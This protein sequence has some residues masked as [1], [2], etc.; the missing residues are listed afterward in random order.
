MA[1]P[2]FKTCCDCGDSLPLANFVPVNSDLFPDGVI[3]FCE[4]CLASR[5]KKKE[6]NFEYIDRLCQW[7]GIPFD[8]QQWLELYGK[9]NYKAFASYAKLNLSAFYPVVDW[10]GCY[11][12][13]KEIQDAAGLENEVPE[14]R[15]AEI[16]RLRKK[17]GEQYDEEDLGYLEDLFQGILQTQNIA[18]KL[19]TDDAIK[20]C[21]ISLLI[22]EKIRASEDFDKILKSYDALRKSADFTSK[23]VKN[24]CDFDS[25]G[26]LFLYCE[27]MGWVN[28]FYDGAMRDTVDLTMRDTQN[29]VR[30]LY[31]NET[32]IGE[33]VERRIQALKIADE[34]EESILSVK[35]D[36]LDDFDSE[37]YSAMDKEDFDEEAGI[38]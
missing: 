27:K 5:I 30:N 10:K 24:A 12:K 6:G 26:E 17:W 22:D 3:P 11:E 9:L 28:K 35:E 4:D 7:V 23:N 31:K 8:V 15:E 36:G 19:Q 21:K 18:G 33:D 38:Q 29:W 2:L 37:S 14:I 20:L 1:K 25:I 32:G 34:M 16:N 13:Y